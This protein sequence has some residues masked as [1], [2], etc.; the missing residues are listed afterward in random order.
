VSNAPPAS[1]E[2]K[3]LSFCIFCG[4]SLGSD[5]I[6]ERFTRLAVRELLAGGHRIVYGGGRVGLMGVVAEE[7][8]KQ[9]GSITGVM[10]APLVKKEL[11]HEGLS[12]IHIVSSMHERKLK[13]SDLADAFLALPGGAGTLEEL[14]EQW[15][16]VQLGL[17]AKPSGVLNINGYFE[18]LRAM[19]SAMV[20]AGFLAYRHRGSLIFGNSV[21]EIL[22]AIQAFRPPEPK[23]HF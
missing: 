19:V 22:D 12:A 17:H 5:P 23:W 13:M 15:T 2:R 4:S 6:Y 1:N 9:G 7:A 18:P 14:F 3:Q 20:D 21:A 10:P 11:L 8:L 16:W